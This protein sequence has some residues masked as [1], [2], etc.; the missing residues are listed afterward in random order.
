MLQT[1]AVAGVGNL[2]KYICEELLKDERFE[3]VVLARQVS[4]PGHDASL[5]LDAF[6][7]TEK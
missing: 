4:P 3:V 6:K 2:G 5:L 1:I 7:W